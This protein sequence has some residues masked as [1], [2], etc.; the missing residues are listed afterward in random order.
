MPKRLKN[1]YFTQEKVLFLASLSKA[2]KKKNNLKNF[3]VT[4]RSTF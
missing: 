2:I 3:Y 4:K 1:T